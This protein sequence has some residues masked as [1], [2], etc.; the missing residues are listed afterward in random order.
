MATELTYTDDDLRVAVA[1]SAN[2]HEVMRALGLPTTSAGKIRIVRRQVEQLG[3]DTSHFRGKRRWT[4][5]QLRQAVIGCHTWND[6][7]TA[8]GLTPGDSDARTR[9]KAQAIRLGLDISHL[10]R[11]R[12]DGSP[13]A[14]KPALRHLRDAGSAL[15]ATWFA[16]CGCPVSWPLEPAIY[17]LIAVTPTGLQRVQVKT[18]TQLTKDGWLVSVGRR[19][20]SPG[21]RVSAI[22]YDPDDIDLFFIVDGD[23]TMYVIPSR[24]LAGRVRILLRSY[25][26]YIVG[27]AAGYLRDRAVQSGNPR[28]PFPMT[29]TSST[30][31]LHE[32]HR[33]ERRRPM[34]SSVS[35]GVTSRP[36]FA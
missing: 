28:P 9:V 16:L 32:I 24:V 36:F 34:G 5:S 14:M 18:T 3:L 23:L 8:L 15:A 7:L 31:R 27:N 1:R 19:P 17:D 29:R 21:N 30:A 26:A 33:R 35:S 10:G 13:P 11:S 4:D 25:A 2:W 22:P 20:Y 12:P 6:V